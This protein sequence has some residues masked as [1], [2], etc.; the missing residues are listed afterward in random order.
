MKKSIL[1]V[2]NFLSST[3]GSRGVCE[4][5][6]LQLATA[7][8]EVYTTS[9]REGRL[10]RLLDMIQTTWSEREQYSVAHVDVYSGPSFIWADGVSA[11]LRRLRKPF[12]LT[13][14]GGNLP[15]FA[16]KWPAWVS[17]V[18]SRATYVTT[19]SSF[20][21]QSMAPYR[22]DIQPIPNALDL[23]TYTFR[24]RI[25]PEPRLVWLRA[26]HKIYNPALAPQAAKLLVDE[27]PN[28]RLVMIGPD[29]GDGSVQQT[30]SIVT[31]LGLGEYVYLPGRV[32]KSDVPTWLNR[33]DIFINTTNVDNTP[34]SVI[35][36]MACGLC[37]VSTSVGGIPYLL[38][39]GHD[40]LLVPPDNP[41]AMADAVRRVLTEPGLAERL[42]QNARA[43]AASN[44]WSVV[45][46]RWE[47]LFLSSS[48]NTG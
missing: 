33:A 44:D 47:E 5:L 40:A 6:S 13:L 3:R 20:L 4:D 27:F 30:R 39:H 26:F 7:G 45:L 12:V 16:T 29:K 1:I 36:A 48:L 2:G 31:N 34:V 23:C 38:D 42:S 21:L 8:W 19:P 43:K 32:P 17:R 25:R 46:P 14:H 18:L 37:V 28:L 24:P 35:E 11:I 22:A 15:Q 10:R 9:H 41:V